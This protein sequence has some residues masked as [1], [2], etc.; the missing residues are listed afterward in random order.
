[1]TPIPNK[2]IRSRENENLGD[3]TVGRS[4]CVSVSLK[5]VS[6]LESQLLRSEDPPEG[7]G[8]AG[9]LFGAGGRQVL[10]QEEGGGTRRSWATGVVGLKPVGQSLPREP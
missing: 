2:V 9:F 1:M 5:V 8:V 6:T 10:E 4:V 3:D 7:T